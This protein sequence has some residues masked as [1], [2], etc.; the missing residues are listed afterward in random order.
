MTFFNTRCLR[1]PPTAERY[2]TEFMLLS[3]V[4]FFFLYVIKLCGGVVYFYL[5]GEKEMRESDTYIM[6]RQMVAILILNPYLSKVLFPRRQ[7]VERKSKAN[8]NKSKRYKPPE[9]A[10][11][12]NV[13]SSSKKYRL[14]G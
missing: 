7:R 9:K 2:T 6:G 4:H 5:I 14:R 8:R 10:L 3:V 13:E 1:I 12:K 11:S